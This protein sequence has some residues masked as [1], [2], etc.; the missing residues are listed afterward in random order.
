MSIKTKFFFVILY[1]LLFMGIPIFIL[2]LGFPQKVCLVVYGCFLICFSIFSF[3]YKIP[4]FNRHYQY[5]GNGF[6]NSFGIRH[7][8]AYTIQLFIG[9]VFLIGSLING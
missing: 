5:K 4:V 9:L 1:Y 6:D 8:F 7:Y 3:I 2:K